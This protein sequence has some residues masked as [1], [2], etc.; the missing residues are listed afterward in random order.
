MTP[1]DFFAVRDRVTRLFAWSP[2]WG[3]AAP[4]VLREFGNDRARFEAAS[5][6]AVAF[7]MG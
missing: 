5:D 6:L 4:L 2:M 7:A 3:R 1:A